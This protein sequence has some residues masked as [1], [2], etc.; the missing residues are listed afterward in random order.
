MIARFVSV[1]SFLLFCLLVACGANGNGP[2]EPAEPV[3]STNVVDGLWYCHTIDGPNV[4]EIDG[5][6]TCHRS[7]ARCEKF[8][9]VAERMEFRPTTCQPQPRAFC[10]SG[11]WTK[12]PQPIEACFKSGEECDRVFKLHVQENP[13]VK[14]GACTEQANNSPPVGDIH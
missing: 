12:H 9:A 5:K 13:D 6:N 11:Y 2:H 10:F 3:R 14:F 8:F 1:G 4:R 7:R